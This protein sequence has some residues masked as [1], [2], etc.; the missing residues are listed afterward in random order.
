MSNRLKI[1]L[2]AVATLIVLAVVFFWSNRLPRAMGSSSGGSPA[3]ASHAEPD[4]SINRNAGAERVSL[5]G[6]RDPVAEGVRVVDADREAGKSWPLEGVVLDDRDGRPVPE[7]QVLLMEGGSLNDYSE[8]HANASLLAKTKTDLD[9]RFRLMVPGENVV[10]VV[11]RADGYT[12]LVKGLRIAA[13]SSVS[14]RII[15][16]GVL[17]GVVRAADGLPAESARVYAIPADAPE[18]LLQSPDN[19]VLGSGHRW[20]SIKAIADASGAYEISGLAL[21]GVYLLRAV[22][23]GHAPSK[24]LKIHPTQEVPVLFRD[25]VLGQLGGA[26]LRVVTPEGRPPADA[27]GFLDWGQGFPHKIAPEEPGIFRFTELVPGRHS[28]RVETTDH[29]IAVAAFDVVAGRT[30]EATVRL[31]AGAT[32]SGVV[33]DDRG[34]ALAGVKVRAERPY[35]KKYRDLSESEGSTTT[36]AEGHFQ[37]G[38]LRPGPHALFHHAKGHDGITGGPLDAPA[39]RVH[40]VAIRK[41]KLSFLVVPP[42]GAEPPKEIAV[43]ASTRPMN[44]KIWGWESTGW[45]GATVKLEG[46]KAEV[47]VS[48][49]PVV[50]WVRVEGFAPVRLEAEPEPGKTVDLGRVELSV[51]LDLSGRVTDLTG[52]PVSGASVTAEIGPVGSAAAVTSKSG[53]FLLRHLPEGELG[54]SV[55]AEGYIVQRLTVPDVARSPGLAV[56]LRRGGLLLGTVV[57]RDGSPVTGLDLHLFD[58]DKKNEDGHDDYVSTDV[59]GRFRSRLAAGEYTVEVWRKHV[60]V[61][62]TAAELQEGGETKVRIVLD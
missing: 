30:V 47:E 48:A 54:V 21:G 50:V 3:R 40:L 5:P 49:C 41:A 52:S 38:G 14:L 31:E 18:T 7:A 42:S 13:A 4:V 11:V 12:E 36:D 1:T 51:G 6:G 37:I 60:L 29:P 46:G 22:K 53:D 59:Q 20:E 25:L 39:V 15:P 43:S 32:I 26:V 57:G 62:K 34:N 10:S 23:K 61:K 2:T 55:E 33:V 58:P 56:P 8:M 27:T 24:D 19:T 44:K 28:L 17:R 35:A 45:S 16:G 9:G